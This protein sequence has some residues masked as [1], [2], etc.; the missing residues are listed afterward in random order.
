MGEGV[1]VDDHE[2]EDVRDYP[3]KVFIAQCYGS[4]PRLVRFD[5]SGAWWIPD[6]LPPG[7]KP[8][9]L[10]THDESTFNA[11]DAKRQLWI[12]NAKPPLRPK[13]NGKGIIVSGFLTP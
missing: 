7:E 10:V 13:S 9:I 11:T 1:Y 8:L 12:F 2:R 5:E 4:Q 3:Q 6:T